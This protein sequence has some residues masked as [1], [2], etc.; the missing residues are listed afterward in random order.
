M[1]LKMQ[2]KTIIWEIIWKKSEIQN[3]NFTFIHFVW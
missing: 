3:D 2:L 1:Q